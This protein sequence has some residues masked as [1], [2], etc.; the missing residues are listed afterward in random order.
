M[1][2]PTLIENHQYDVP[3]ETAFGRCI[4]NL[5]ILGGRLYVS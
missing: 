2:I 4:L 1:F 5:P 3:L